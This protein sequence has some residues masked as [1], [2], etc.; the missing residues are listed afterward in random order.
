MSAAF[1]SMASEPILRCQDVALV[2]DGA[3][4][5]AGLHLTLGRGERGLVVGANG[6][7][8]T[9]L[10]LGL[11]RLLPLR[12]KLLERPQRIG[13]APQEPAFPRHRRCGEYLEEL[14]AL[15]GARGAQPRD[16]ARAAL[17]R[18]DLAAARRRTIGEL[19]RGWRQRLNL[20][21]AWLGAPELLILDEPQTALDPD[22]MAAL[23]R[24]IAARE[25]SAT[26]IVAPPDV[27]CDALAPV[28]LRLGEARA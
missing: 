1:R 4:L 11:C 15:S 3:I 22:G 16:W 12:A 6:S 10:A 9:T 24:A 20:A 5:A 2:R 21:R 17:E 13:L 26:L 23:R 8:K 19:S 7:G 27:G 28:V 18:F 14:A 25:D